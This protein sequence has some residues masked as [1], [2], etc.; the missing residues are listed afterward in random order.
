MEIQ[1]EIFRSL[2]TQRHKQDFTARA[3][4]ICLLSILQYTSLSRATGWGLVSILPSGLANTHFFQLCH[5]IMMSENSPMYSCL[6]WMGFTCKN[7]L[8]S[9]LHT[10]SFQ[11]H[12][13]NTSPAHLNLDL[14]PEMLSKQKLDG[15]SLSQQHSVTDNTVT[16]T[17]MM[18]ENKL[19]S[20][21]TWLKQVHL[22]IP[23][24]SV[25][26]TEHWGL[27]KVKGLLFIISSLLCFALH[28]FCTSSGLPSSHVCILCQDW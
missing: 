26:K 4:T 6:S 1:G 27:S 22:Q 7:S 12:S 8:Q 15:S 13:T 9:H 3:K 23:G 24:K 21:Q 28:V 5:T 20:K 17:A 25:Q 11:I 16:A 14:T 19:G 2:L 18:M 10:C